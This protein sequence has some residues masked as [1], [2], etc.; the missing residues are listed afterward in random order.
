MNIVEFQQVSLHLHQRTLLREI[1][2]QLNHGDFMV[3]LGSNGSGK[4]TLFKL[5]YR[6]YQPTIGTILFDNKP[7]ERY[8]KKTFFSKM[9]I[10]TQHC[11][12]SL[13]SSL[14]VYENYLL[15]KKHLPAEKKFVRDYFAE[16]NPKLADN[17][18]TIAAN[19]SGGEKQ[20]LALALCLLHPPALL[21][22]D[23]H[24]SALDPKTSAQIM[25]LTAEK[26]AQHHITCFM[27]T[28]H[29]DDALNYG[30]RIIVLSEGKVKKIYNDREKSLLNK[31]D[32]ISNCY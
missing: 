29:L 26:I 9:A 8:R 4:S 17:I 18:N 28:H 15:V 24:T 13:F 19:L 3:V 30:N 12:D 20:A 31:G 22:L 7:L 6:H 23:E 21:L 14:T 25:K 10:L 5:L 2:F 27:T 16:Y 11:H 32:L 1:N